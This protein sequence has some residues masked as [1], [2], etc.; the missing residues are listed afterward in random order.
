MTTPR[1]FDYAAT[2]PVAPEVVSAMC[3]CLD[4]GGNFG[5]AASRSHVFGWR[6][7]EAVERARAQVAALI[8][9]DTREIVWTSG[10][11]EAI[12][13]AL[14]GAVQSGLAEAMPLHVISSAIE[15]KATLDTLAYLSRAEGVEVSYVAP[16]P[17][18]WV[19]VEKIVAAM[20]PETR[21]V[22]LMH[23]NNETGMVNDIASLGAICRAR[24]ILFHVDA[25]QSFGKLQ[26]DV[27]AMNIDL[28]SM[29][30]HKIYGPKGA[31][32]LFVRR[33]PSVRIE[34]QMH[35][36]GHER[37][38]RSGTLA[39]H[40]VVGMGKAAEL[41]AHRMA[42][43]RETQE[44]LRARFLAGLRQTR[45]WALVGAEGPRLP[46]IVN[47]S[48]PDIDG[49]TLLMS[50]RQLAVSSGSACTSA[51]LDPSYVLRAMGLSER[52]AQN[53]LRFSLG[54]YTTADDVD[55]ALA[56]IKQALAVLAKE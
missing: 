30:A 36:G 48:F 43:D 18:G 25:A 12:N 40:Q 13:L 52:V 39:T 50:L 20:R 8:A 17:E 11:T 41:A 45:G 34:A 9:A 5:N 29:S 16:E 23:A 38:M 6:A 54:R 22:S 53:S 10:A 35:G 27:H 47:L 42:T 26:I 2:T 33:H 21:L 55:F 4:L 56:E 19:S 37:G 46:G 1:Y 7:E 51:S 32:A 31:G 28:L 44:A 14:K 49:E 15:H 3:H 24:D